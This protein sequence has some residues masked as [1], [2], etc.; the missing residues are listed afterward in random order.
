MESLELREA[1]VPPCGEN[2]TGGV[3]RGQSPELLLL[4]NQYFPLNASG[5]SRY[6]LIVA[7][8]VL[9]AFTALS[10]EENSPWG[11]GPEGDLRSSINL[12]SHE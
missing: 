12:K 8:D 10:F 7:F 6:L 11:L 3:V 9:K 1:H 2:Y 4:F 5:L